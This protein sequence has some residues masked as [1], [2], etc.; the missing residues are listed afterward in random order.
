MFGGTLVFTVTRSA[1]LQVRRPLASITCSQ[2]L[3]THNT[4]ISFVVDSNGI[5]WKSA[6]TATEDVSTSRNIP[7]SQIT[8]AEWTLFG[9]SGHLRIQ[10]NASSLKH[11]LRFDGFP[12]NDFEKL[13]GALEFVKLE[14]LQMSSVGASFGNVDVNGRKLV[15]SQAILEDA[16][17]EG[18]EFEPRDGPEL[19]S[20]DL[21][22]ISQCVLPGTNRN[23]IEVQFPESDTVEA[24]TDQL[25]KKH[26]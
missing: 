23:E 18:E 14:R 24:G 1:R 7:A 16:D 10:T 20:L 17:E 25:G 4:V 8:G 19:M 2:D 3:S 6:L 22:E 21:T 9:R 5:Q 11:E 26:F 12:P 13:K 15:F